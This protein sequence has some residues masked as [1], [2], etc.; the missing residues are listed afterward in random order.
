[1]DRPGVLFD[2][3]PGGLTG[4]VIEGRFE[5]LKLLETG[6]M[7]DVYLSQQ[8]SLGMTRALKVIKADVTNQE[9]EEKRFRREALALSRLSHENIVQV[10]D[11][12]RLPPPVPLH[13]LVMEYVEGV[14]AQEVVD[15]GPIPPRHAVHIIRQIADALA[16]AHGQGIVHRD[17]KPANI[18]LRGKVPPFGE[19]LL[20][21]K[22]VDFGLVR[23]VT[24]ETLTKI[25]AEEQI[26]GTP[27]FMAPEQCRCIEVGPAAD[28]YALGGVAF[29]M[30][31]GTPVFKSRSVLELIVAHAKRAP[32]RLSERCPELGIV[33]GLEDL[34]HRCLAKE[35]DERPTAEEIKRVLDDL[36]EPVSPDVALAV[37]QTALA[38]PPQPDRV[39]LST[40]LPRHDVARLSSL[41]WADPDDSGVNYTPGVRPVLDA[42]FNQLSTV[43]VNLARR[44]LEVLADTADLKQQLGEIE[45]LEEKIG[46][47]EMDVALLES[48]MAEC[49]V[50][51]LGELRQRRSGQRRRVARLSVKRDEVYRKLFELTLKRGVEIEESPAAQQFTD[52]EQLI[53]QYLRLGGVVAERDRSA[54]GG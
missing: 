20:P 40:R 45:R 21:V 13:Y 17:L 38:P 3:S 54:R 41:I 4:Q 26:L 46:G 19:E 34:V 9:R 1:M 28:I 14:N 43:L 15:R 10:I 52:L 12:G 29:F 24:D 22:I 53:E 36:G 2:L 7:G 47:L 5:V 49:S 11:F 37:A 33:P 18:L 35:P 48:E 39:G 42:L 32:E 44:L 31:S 16:Y 27:R 6:A 23:I 30:L 50:E 25:T 51:E 8:L